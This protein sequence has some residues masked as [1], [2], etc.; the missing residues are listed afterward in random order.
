MNPS[1]RLETVLADFR[2]ECSALRLN[3]H[4]AQAQ[5]IERVCD[6][7]SAAA[8]DFLEWIS[9]G[10]AKLR[11]GRGED[12]FRARRAVWAEDGLAE[13]RGRTWYY[14]QCVVERRKPASITRA[15]ARRGRVA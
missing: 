5:S 12:Y 13:K 7:V 2:E 6:A 10:E 8:R 1:P 9:E 4:Q 15:E 11:S 14:R 3:G